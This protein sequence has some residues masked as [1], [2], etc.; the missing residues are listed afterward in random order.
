MSKFV[1]YLIEDCK[2]HADKAIKKLS[3]AALKYAEGGDDF[4]FY[5]L[6][7]TVSQKYENKEYL[8]YDQSVVSRI[9][10][11]IN[12]EITMGNKIGLLLDIMLTQEDIEKSK[13]SYY[14]HASISRDIFFKFRGE[15]PIYIVTI[16]SSFAA[17]SDIIMGVNLSEQFISQA[18][19][20]RDPVDSLEGDFKRL[21]KFYQEYKPEN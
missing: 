5:H 2:E 18:R 15:I 3:V 1:I 4:E 14:T 6:K 9:E 11:K 20:S 21:F 13:N 16:S 8:F 10:E 7:G 12:N 19:L 17:Y